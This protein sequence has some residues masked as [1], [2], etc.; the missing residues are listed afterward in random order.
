MSLP[1]PF[2]V[3]QTEAPV[4]SRQKEAVFVFGC[5]SGSP[6]TQSTGLWPFSKRD[7]LSPEL[8]LATPA[9]SAMVGQS[10]K[11]RVDT[12]QQA[13]R[14]KLA[15]ISISTHPPSACC[16]PCNLQSNDSRVHFLRNREKENKERRDEMSSVKHYASLRDVCLSTVHGPVKPLLAGESGYR[17][18]MGTS[19]SYFHS[20]SPF[21]ETLL[22]QGSVLMEEEKIQEANKSERQERV[23]EGVE[24]KEEGV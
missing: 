16:L 5:S 3:S 7:H 21:M 6:Q 11:C 18:A 17:E 1:R 22:E 10:W 4:C 19:Q 20:L 14:R 9:F 8:G 2:Q 24:E 12:A 23:K 15:P 13:S